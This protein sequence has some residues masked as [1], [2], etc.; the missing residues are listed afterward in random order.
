MF[1][2]IFS[3]IGLF[4]KQPKFAPLLVF[5]GISC[6]AMDSLADCLEQKVIEKRPIPYDYDRTVKFATTGLFGSCSDQVWYYILERG[7]PGVGNKFV[8]IKVTLDQ[9]FY[10]AFEIICFFIIY[11]LID[12]KSFNGG[13]RELKEKFFEVLTVSYLVWPTLQIIN[14]KFVPFSLRVLY[15]EAA[16]L[17]WSIYLSWVKHRDSKQAT[18]NK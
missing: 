3:R 5:N 1:R 6:L 7:F 4:F 13:I 8:F 17:I 11:N 10:S 16:S 12:G 9:V 15:S 14:F 2:N 18:T